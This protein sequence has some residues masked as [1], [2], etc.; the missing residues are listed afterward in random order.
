M[1]HSI[2]LIILTLWLCSEAWGQRTV[3][4]VGR[5]NVS[6]SSASASQTLGGGNTR[7][8]VQSL[9]GGAG[10]LTN[11]VGSF[12]RSLGRSGGGT[13]GGGG[14]AAGAPGTRAGLGSSGIGALGVG[15]PAALGTMSQ[16]TLSFVRLLSRVGP[17]PGQLAPGPDLAYRPALQAPPL[18][19]AP[20]SRVTSPPTEFHAFFNVRPVAEAGVDRTAEG[21]MVT[22]R[23]Q[24]HV[25]TIVA[26]RRAAALDEFRAATQRSATVEDIDELASVHASLRGLRNLVPR[27]DVLPSWLAAHVALEREQMTVAVTHL[28]NVVERDQD[29]F[30]NLEPLVSSFGDYD[31]VSE[32]SATLRRQMRRYARAG[33]LNRGSMLAQALQAYAAWVIGDSRQ[34]EAALRQARRLGAADASD[35]VLRL[36]EAVDRAAYAAEYNRRERVAER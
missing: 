28:L 24:T 15:A 32:G 4:V 1:Q 23:M 14:G 22:E 25:Q 17:S 12:T 31:E 20:Q 13:F 34:V 6:G 35:D 36:V 8:S 21:D 9:R 10:S 29:V 3:G 2:P 27:D 16:P 26:T 11:T 7:G 30:T 18:T 19:I 33:D 5:G